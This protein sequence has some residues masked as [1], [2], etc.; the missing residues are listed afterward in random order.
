MSKGITVVGLEDDIDLGLM[1]GVSGIGLTLLKI[2][3]IF[4]EDILLLD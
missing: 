2:E 1:T 4:K 3:G